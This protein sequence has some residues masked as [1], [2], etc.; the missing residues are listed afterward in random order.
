MHTEQP[1]HVEIHTHREREIQAY[2]AMVTIEQKNGKSIRFAIYCTQ[3][4]VT[5]KGAF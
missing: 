2:Y 5:E 3:L 4:Y 1:T